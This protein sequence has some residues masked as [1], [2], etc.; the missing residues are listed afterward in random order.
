MTVGNA[1]REGDGC[2]LLVVGAHAMDAE[3]LGGALAAHVVKQGERAHLL[4][5]TRGERGHPILDADA[6]A[7]QLEGEMEE[8]S[9]MLG[10]SFHWA[11]VPAPLAKAG[12]DQLS[13]LV[14]GVMQELRP[15]F[16]LTHWIGSW[17][18]GHIRAHEAVRAAVGAFREA[19][20]SVDLLYGEN[21]EDLLGFE[22]TGF[23]DVSS[24]VDDWRRA[25]RAYELFRR[26]EPQSGVDSVVPYA[27][28]YEAALRVR[29]LH[30]GFEQ[31]QAV[32]VGPWPISVATRE[33]FKWLNL[34]AA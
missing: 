13:N 22:P 6:F 28:Y 30:A 8:A 32:M 31:A 1:G 3:L 29:G 7:R 19:G 33:R 4:H 27:G 12:I 18:A 25:L 11:G 16:V 21:C 34:P 26:S 2:E 14:L 15:T 24:A 20:Q 10:T 9:R 5:L 23:A 17:H